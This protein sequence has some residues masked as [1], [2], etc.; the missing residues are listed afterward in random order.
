VRETLSTTPAP[1]AKPTISMSR[2]S[3][4]VGQSFTI[5]WSTTDATSLSRVCTASG[6]GYTVN[7]ALAVSGS[8]ALTAQSDWVGD[9]SSCT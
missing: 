6:T 7:E 1:T 3:Q 2:F 4:V 9:P 5:T 8:R